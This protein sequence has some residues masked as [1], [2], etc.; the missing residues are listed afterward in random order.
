MNR[1]SRFRSILKW[2]ST[3]LCLLTATAFAVSGWCQITLTFAF[4]STG[5]QFWLGGGKAFIDWWHI[6]SDVDDALPSWGFLSN[7][8]WPEFGLPWS[9]L[10]ETQGPPLSRLGLPLLSGL[11]ILLVP[12]ALIWW[13]ETR[14]PFPNHCHQCGYNLTGNA[15]GRCPECGSVELPQEMT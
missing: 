11:A 5:Y 10:P 14:R 15:S 8:G 2:S 13:R 12:T 7:L 4:R 6:S 9:L 1:R 3:L